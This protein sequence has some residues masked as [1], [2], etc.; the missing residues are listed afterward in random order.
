VQIAS[1][2]D[3]GA[4]RVVCATFRAQVGVWGIL[5]PDCREDVSG[6][7]TT[8]PIPFTQHSRP[9]QVRARHRCGV[10]IRSA[11]SEVGRVFLVVIDANTPSRARAREA[12]TSRGCLPLM[13]H[14]ACSRDEPFDG[15]SR[16]DGHSTPLLLAQHSQPAQPGSFCPPGPGL[17]MADSTPRSGRR[18][19][20]RLPP[21]RSHHPPGLD[22]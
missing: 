21:R 7:T 8:P 1:S 4:D 12:T 2:S 22:A 15:T 11:R 19:P 13:V 9:A 20:L 10:P 18:Y 6:V 5:H 17:S 3:L 16:P 14:P